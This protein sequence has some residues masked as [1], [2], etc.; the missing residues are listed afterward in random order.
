MGIGN[1]V[2]TT[3]VDK[4]NLGNNIGR[5]QW[6]SGF[7]ILYEKSQ[8]FTITVS[9]HINKILNKMYISFFLVKQ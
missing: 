5:Y 8:Q 4:K 9:L 6:I 2:T 1:L 3:F 7:A